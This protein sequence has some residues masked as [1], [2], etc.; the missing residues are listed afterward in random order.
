MI[1][2]DVS[3]INLKYL[4]A[5]ISQSLFRGCSREIFVKYLPQNLTFYGLLQKLQIQRLATLASNL[6]LHLL[7]IFI[8]LFQDLL[9]NPSLWIVKSNP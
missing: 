5:L 2:S 1:F 7:C 8:G 9:S 3:I 4:V 6:C